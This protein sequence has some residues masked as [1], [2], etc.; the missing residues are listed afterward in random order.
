MWEKI[1]KFL[2][3]VASIITITMLIV[4]GLPKMASFPEPLV[5]S[6]GSELRQPPSNGDVATQTIWERL[7]LIGQGVTGLAKIALYVGIFIGKLTVVV[8][9][10][11]I[12]ARLVYTSSF[13]KRARHYGLHPWSPWD[14][15]MPEIL[16]G[17]V[18]LVIVAIALAVIFP[19]FVVSKWVWDFVMF[20][21]EYN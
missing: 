19:F 9:T 14:K 3:Y 5:S 11:W 1:G 10:P 17:T 20:W 4:T 12:P 7:G 13:K 8:F 18:Y 2:G 6:N 15:Y 21:A 16:S